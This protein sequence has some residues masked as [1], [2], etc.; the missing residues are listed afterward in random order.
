MP[1]ST[2]RSPLG[3]IA[4]RHRLPSMSV[5]RSLRMRW[6][7]VVVRCSLLM[8]LVPNEEKWSNLNVNVEIVGGGILMR[9]IGWIQEIQSEVFYNISCVF[10]RRQWCSVDESIV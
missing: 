1:E 2:E 8:M 9:E 7:V 10:C 3:Y 4:T 5:L 6:P